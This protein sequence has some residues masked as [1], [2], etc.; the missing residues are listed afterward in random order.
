MIGTALRT[1]GYAA[2]VAIAA[3]LS[4]ACTVS[5]AGVAFGTYNPFSGTADT[6]TGSVTVA[7]TAGAGSGP[8]TL[9]LSIGGGASY[10]ARAMT[11]GANMMAYQLYDDAGRT[12]IWGDG[13]GGSAVVNGV[14]TVPNSGGSSIYQI[15]GR[16]AAGLVVAPGSYA[17]TVTVTISY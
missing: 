2:S 15:Y 6:A 4:A 12:I 14:D 16:V 9:S 13:T 7:C 11:S 3:P 10:A 5:T 8:Y 17:D 1:V